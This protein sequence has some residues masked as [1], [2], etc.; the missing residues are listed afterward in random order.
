MPHKS[1]NSFPSF[2][3]ESLTTKHN[4]ILIV[5][6]K[7][8]K[9]EKNSARNMQK[10]RQLIH[11]SFWVFLFIISA[12][13]FAAWF[14]I[15]LGYMLEE[16]S[17]AYILTKLTIR[18]SLSIGIILLLIGCLVLICISVNGNYLLNIHAIKVSFFCFHF[19]FEY[20]S[21]KAIHFFKRLEL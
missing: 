16:H 5:K 11:I 19:T 10:I 9:L 6:R 7:K 21:L 14:I 18:I 4:R 20:F 1:N 12:I 3:T 15:V 13:V 8:R 17:L 2:L